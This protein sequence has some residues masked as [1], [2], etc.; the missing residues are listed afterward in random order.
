MPSDADAPAK[1]ARPLRALAGATGAWTWD[2]GAGRLMGDARFANLYGLD[3]A[4]AAAG[5]PTSEFFTPIHPEDRMRMRIAVAGVL[6][7]SDLLNREYRVVAPD[8]ST[9]WVSARARAEHDDRGELLRFGGILTDITDQKRVEEQLRIAQTAGGVG[10]FEYVDGF[11]TVSVS[12]QFCRLL[13]LHLA[14]SL[15]VRTI[16]AVVADGGEPLIRSHLGEEAAAYREVSIARADNGEHRWLACRGEHRRDRAAPGARFIGV[17]YDIT[18]SK[19]TEARLR[20]LAA[21]M[22]QQVQART[23]ERDRVWR[24]SRDLIAVCG[25]DGAFRALNPAW[26]SLLGY[27]DEELIGRPFAEV[28]HADDL[29]DLRARNAE[30]RE[31]AIRDADVRIRGKDGAYRWIN[32]TVAPEADAYYCVG[33]DIT[34]RK[35]LE[36]QLRQSQKMEAV[37]Q[38]T[39]GL[40]HDLNNMLTGVMGGMDL[41]RRRIAGGQIEAATKF[42]DAAV[43]SAERA[44]ALTH[45][46]L[47]F[48][49]RQSLDT[50]AVDV[51]ALAASMED[52]LRRT[53]GEQIILTVA[54]AEGGWPAL[55]DQNQLESALLNLVINARDAMPAGGRL[56]IET[57]NVHLDPVE[58]RR[59][60]GPE[61]GDYVV[62]RVRDTGTGMPAAV[63]EKAFDPF[64]T[65]KPLGQGTGLGLSMVY[66]FVRQ[67]GGEV[68]IDSAPGLGTTV[69]LWLPRAQT[70]AAA[71]AVLPTAPRGA[72]ETLLVVEDDASVRMLVLEVLSEL[73]YSGVEAPEGQVALR[74]LES[75]QPIDLLVT[76]VGLPGLNGR[77]L[78]DLAREKRPNLK[79]LF[80]TGYAANATVRSEFLGPGMDMITKPF[81]MDALGRKVSE[82]LGA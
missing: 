67:T 54:G 45:R 44:A 61:A 27:A 78:A 68:T 36:D 81:A 33:R 25:A 23:Q 58:A 24:L 16:N 65:T 39:G 31:A 5:L 70:Q 21:N 69:S 43:A 62:L 57:A 76:D 9:R 50:R 15:P 79:V 37:G 38:L 13:G 71:A 20:E 7:G 22:E 77:Q 53:L 64:F 75:G 11:G 1:T 47:A 46:L 32:W 6:H 10:T 35:Q 19:R 18:D 60:G 66:G 17:I 55:S 74:I 8:G 52:M 80:I 59:R 48:A 4:K 12:E 34:E 56:T 3:P 72:G 73:G 63:I 51:N 30:R 82:M 28:A 41:V 29:R 40:A 2:A 14:D 49:R 42:I 26:G